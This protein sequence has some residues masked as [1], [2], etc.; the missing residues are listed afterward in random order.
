MA[1][2]D[3]SSSMQHAPEMVALLAHMG[4]RTA[5]QRSS[6]ILSASK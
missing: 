2:A 4:R 6:K 1:E 3:S 5:A